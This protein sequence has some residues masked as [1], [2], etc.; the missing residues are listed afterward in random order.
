MT[1]LGQ[2]RPFYDVRL[3]VRFAR[4]RTRPG[5]FMSTRPRRHRKCA[6]AWEGGRLGRQAMENWLTA[7]NPRLQS[8]QPAGWVQVETVLRGARALTPRGALR[9]LGWRIGQAPAAKA[10]LKSIS[11]GG[12]GEAE[13]DRELL[14]LV[15]AAATADRDASF[16]VEC[17]KLQGPVAEAPW[18]RLELDD[19][20]EV[21]LIHVSSDL[22]LATTH[23]AQ[24]S[25]ASRFALS[26]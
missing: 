18:R 20:R 8:P 24:S 17:I 12:I 5:R 16:M 22:E 3:N 19:V 11:G 10:L 21:P 23:L 9:R 25:S 6:G 4:K 7:N 26:E 14:P 15:T 2:T 13:A 1:G